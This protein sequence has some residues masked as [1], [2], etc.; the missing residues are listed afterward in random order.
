MKHTSGSRLINIIYPVSLNGCPQQT[1]HLN[2]HVRPRDQQ[3]LQP[4]TPP[5][6][7]NSR[8][9]MEQDPR[10]RRFNGAA[11]QAIRDVVQRRVD[12]YLPCAAYEV[13]DWRVD[14]AGLGRVVG[15][16]EAELGS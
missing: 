1:S 9:H 2:D 10:V 3:R 13:S 14:V 15:Q 7:Q 5:S 11:A 6:V 8:G 4:I 16:S 12:P